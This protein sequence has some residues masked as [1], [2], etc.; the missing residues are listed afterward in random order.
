MARHFWQAPCSNYIHT[1][2]QSIVGVGLCCARTRCATA[3]LHFAP[4][5]QPSV[6]LLLPVA[7][8]CANSRESCVTVDKRAAPRYVRRQSY[9]PCPPVGPDGERRSSPRLTP[10]PSNT[11]LCCHTDARGGGMELEC[12]AWS[13]HLP[14]VLS[15]AQF[16]SLNS[17]GGGGSEG[18]GK[19]RAPLP[20]SY[21]ATKLKAQS[22]ESMCE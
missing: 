2:L 15:A 1:A 17:T 7:R 20:L 8:E 6:A 3:I 4:Q 22:S 19:W 21:V 13:V 18:R 5:P 16:C 10:L 11:Q 9:V 14:L 12:K